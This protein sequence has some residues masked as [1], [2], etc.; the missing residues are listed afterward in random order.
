MGARP[1]ARQ[2]LTPFSRS[3]RS[4]S[5]AWGEGR[6]VSMSTSVPSMSKK[7]IWIELMGGSSVQAFFLSIAQPGGFRQQKE[8]GGQSF[9]RS[10]LRVGSFFQVRALAGSR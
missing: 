2:T 5:T 9:L 6:L 7:A 10:G 8:P 1:V 3:R 4:V